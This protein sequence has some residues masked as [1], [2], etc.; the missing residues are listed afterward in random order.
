MTSC[1]SICTSWL[2][3]SSNC[4]P[5][6]CTNALLWPFR[7]AVWPFVALLQYEAWS[8]ICVATIYGSSHVSASL[9]PLE[10]GSGGGGQVPVPSTRNRRTVRAAAASPDVT[11]A[12]GIATTSMTDMVA[13]VSREVV[14]QLRDECDPTST[15]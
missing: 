11:V 4:P 8:G 13:L 2:V 3:I 6:A 5:L 12:L 14:K 1:S 9:C 10:S 7:C 15:K